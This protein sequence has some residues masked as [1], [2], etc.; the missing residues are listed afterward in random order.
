MTWKETQAYLFD[1]LPMFQRIGPAAYK[2]NL[3]NTYAICKLLGN[4]QNNFKSVHVAGTNGKGSTSHALAAIFQQAGYKTG[5]YTSPHLKD[6][7]ERIR[8]N[9]KM[10]SR[11]DVIRFTEKH[12]KDFEKIKPS[13]F[14]MTVGLAFDYFSNQKV[15]IA[16]VETG[17]G[18]RL[19]STNIITPELC[20]I[21]NIGW[22]H[23]N[24]L[25]DTLPKIAVEK[26]GIIKKQV[27]VII[28][29]TTGKLKPI[30]VAKAAEMDAPLYFANELMKVKNSRLSSNGLRVMDV[31]KRSKP[32]YKKLSLDLTG[33]Y[34]TKNIKSVLLAVSILQKSGFNLPEKVIREALKN[35]GNLTGLKGRWQILSKNPLT[36]ADTAHNVNGIAEVIKQIKAM[37]YK[38]LHMV[39]GMVNDKEIDN[40]LKLLPAEATY[41]FCQAKIPRA[42]PAG[43]LANRAKKY[44]LNGVVIPF[45]KAAMRKAQQNAKK[46]DLVFVSGST[47]VV[48]EIC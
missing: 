44:K 4:P 36:I 2:A 47:F 1:A 42:L 33:N 28:G 29:E 17:L 30:F 25:G 34:Q 8:I 11:Q 12:Q 23:M 45:V 26:A 19:D 15:D 24:L 6:F 43:E 46:N 3:D 40:M 39:I 10:I 7:R 9:G 5:L 14:E 21:T 31:N 16:I 48:G 18:G 41:Y 27:P 13:F 35:I 38:Q 22:D 32:L 20:L 37:H